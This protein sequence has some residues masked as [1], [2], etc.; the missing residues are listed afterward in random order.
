MRRLA[1]CAVTLVW[2]AAAT[3]GPS[4]TPGA[5]A[6]TLIWWG[7]HSTARLAVSELSA[8]LAAP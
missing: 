4:T 8:A 1:V 3:A 6:L 2:A 7:P 5:T